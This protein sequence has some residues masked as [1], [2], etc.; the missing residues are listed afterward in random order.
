MSPSTQ[1]KA[2][3][4]VSLGDGMETCWGCRCYFTSVTKGICAHSIN[5][6]IKQS[7]VTINTVKQQPVYPWKRWCRR[8]EVA[9]MPVTDPSCEQPSCYGTQETDQGLALLQTPPS[10]TT[11]QSTKHKRYKWI[12]RMFVCMLLLASTEQNNDAPVNLVWYHLNDHDLHKKNSPHCV[13]MCASMRVCVCV[14]VCVHKCVHACLCMHAGIHVCI[15]YI[16]YTRVYAC[17]NTHMHPRQEQEE[18]ECWK[19]HR[20]HC[21][22]RLTPAVLTERKIACTYLHTPVQLDDYGLLTGAVPDMHPSLDPE[23]AVMPWLTFNI[24]ADSDMYLYLYIYIQTQISLRLYWTHALWKWD[25]KLPT[26]T[27]NLIFDVK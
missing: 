27:G 23:P 21:Q 4:C 13:C 9:V 8:V 1:W 7:T 15:V 11:N 26:E 12:R 10:E 16:H 24:K 3:T 2:T 20:I 5:Q 17:M 22:Q 19:F 6:S 25:T 18:K 14:Q